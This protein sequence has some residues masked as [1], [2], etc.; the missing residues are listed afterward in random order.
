LKKKIL[1]SFLFYF[2]VVK[3][4]FAQK[5]VILLND[6]ASSYSI[7]NSLY[8]FEEEKKTYTISEVSKPN[9]PFELNKGKTVPNLGFTE[10]NFWFRF[11]VK[12]NWTP[13]KLILEIPYPFFN[14]LEV[15]V[16]KQGKITLR[17][18]VGDH[19]P[20]SKRKI[21]NKNFIFE[22]DF[23]PNEEALIFAHILCNGE[24]TSFPVRLLKSI[25][26]SEYYYQEQ[27][28][29]G[30]YYG[31]LLFALFLSIF[32]GVSLKETINFWYFFYI[33]SIG[34]F[35]LALDGL[36]FQYLWPNNIWLANHIIPLAGSAGIFFLIKFTQRLLLTDKLAPKI[37]K[38]LNAVAAVVFLFFVA[39]MFENPLYSW[40]LKGLN[41]LGLIANV[42]V[43]SA[44]IIVFRS[45][46][47][48]AR[49]FLIAF[50]LLILG[51]L[52]AL[53]KNFGILPRIFLTEYGIQ[54]GSAIEIIFLSF[55]LSERVKVLKDEK[56]EV[57][58]L[59]IEQYKEN[60]RIQAEIN[61][62]LERKVEE[63]TFEILEQNKVISEKNKDIT[64]SINYAK[65]IQEALLPKEEVKQLSAHNFFIL[66]KPRDIVSGDF[67]WYEEQNGILIFCVADCTGHGVPGALMSMIGTTVL[68]QILDDPFSF[69]AAEI[70]S[71]LDKRIIESL[72]Q[73]SDLNPTKDGMDT[74]ICLINTRSNKAVF[75]GALRPMVL[76]RE[77]EIIAYS[78]SSYSI[79]GYNPEIKKEFTNHE[80]ELK[81]GDTIYMFSDGYADQFGGPKNKKL[82]IKNFKHNLAEI[83]EL[84]M[85][86]QKEILYQSFEN[87]RGQNEQVDDV[88]VMGYKC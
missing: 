79:G 80:I 60:N 18:T 31:V 56:T 63:R 81:K 10:N 75:A 84:P 12:N 85:N 37:C 4:L 50:S 25:E 6:S 45:N 54:M 77:N 87:W 23:A 30:F 57:Q 22:L 66:Y 7:Y 58:N 49:Y 42:L 27:L 19:F 52:L 24:A 9:F 14:Q 17:E 20:F 3:T 21:K 73:Q 33:L 11:S 53:L 74:A 65:R 34:I 15:Y 71:K 44:S 83:S 38:T 16:I 76:I 32:L 62:E 88:L 61:V 46:Y 69:N 5:E 55:A 72:K 51:V 48:P 40:S 43:F 26:L 39:S 59:L 2:V 82:M 35:Q 41:F 86:Q 47:K 64:D 78:S 8:L 36:A 13:R 28:M 29:L 68:R 67:Y 1:F 70:L